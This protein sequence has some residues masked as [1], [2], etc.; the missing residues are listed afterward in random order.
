MSTQAYPGRIFRGSVYEITPGGNPDQR[1]F[2]VRIKPDDTI[3]VGLTLEVNIMVAERQNAL[4]VPSAAVHNDSVWV[5]ANER[6]RRVPVQLGIR[7]SDSSEVRQGLSGRDC[8][9]TDAG[10]TLKE[11]EPVRVQGC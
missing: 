1:A 2:R 3:P 6:A 9:I 10:S 7:G 11:G 4:L 8:V 5:V